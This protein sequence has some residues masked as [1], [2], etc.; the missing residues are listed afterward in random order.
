MEEKYFINSFFEKT[1]DNYQNL[2]KSKAL[3][4]ANDFNITV[5]KILI[6]IY[7]ELDFINP[8]IANDGKAVFRNMM[9]FGYSLAEIEDFF[10]E[11]NKYNQLV[12]NN[13]EQKNKFAV[14]IQKKLI[15][16]LFL[17]RE[18]VGLSDNDLNV[19]YTFLNN[20]NFIDVL[21]YF[22]LKLYHITEN[23]REVEHFEIESK[24]DGHEEKQK[25]NQLTFEFSGASGFA[26]IIVILSAIAVVCLAVVMINLLGG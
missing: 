10:E 21:D 17:K 2:A 26:S 6:L 15:D 3:S 23:S 9:K 8:R 14:S 1:L 4:L 24:V 19:F 20:L 25:P 13:D 12:L 7:G 11:F 22:K 5:L 18:V 16:M